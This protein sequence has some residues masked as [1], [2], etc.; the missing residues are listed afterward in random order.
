[1]KFT[2]RI[3][4]LIL[5]SLAIA[6]STK[7]SIKVIAHRGGANLAPENTRAAFIEAMKFDVDMIEIDVEQTLDSIIVVIH[8]RT[9]DRT[10][11]GKGYV[12]SLTYNYISSLDAGSWYNSKYSNEKIMTLDEVLE[13]LNGRVTLLIEIKEGSERYPGIEK[14]TAEAIQRFNAYSWTI[15]Q[16]FNE[17]AIKRISELDPNIETY[18]LLGKNYPEYFLDLRKRIETNQPAQFSYEGIAIHHSIVRPTMIDSIK[19]LGIRVFTWTVNDINDMQK[20]IESGVDGIITDS[21]DKLI[22]LLQE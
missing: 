4:V 5:V 3:T 14:R 2:I 12:D 19:S 20:M 22:D 15:V 16:S 1:M 7:S 8:D 18:Y 10:T 11:N 6:C 9:V 21:P 17:K 13:L